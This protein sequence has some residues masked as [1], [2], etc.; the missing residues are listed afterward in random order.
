MALLD[1][2]FSPPFLARYRRE[3]TGDLD[4]AGL[5]QFQADW[6]AL[7]ALQKRRETVLGR[8]A[9]QAASP[10]GL[11]AAIEACATRDEVEDMYLS[12]R[13]KRKSRGTLARERGLE[14]LAR[15]L[16]TPV[17]QAASLEA[18]AAPFVDAH[19]G[20]PDAAAALDGARHII[21]EQIA[22]DPALRQQVRAFYADTGTLHCQVADDKKGQRSKYEMY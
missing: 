2:G 10:D 1:A 16:L 4:E 17:A 20:L 11:R 5:R 18:V 22:H 19:R 13:I 15:A 8:L 12:C 21:A 6:H 9:E 3:Q 7:V 14:P